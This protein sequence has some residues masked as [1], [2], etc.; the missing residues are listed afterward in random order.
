MEIGRPPEAL[1]LTH[2]VPTGSIP[3]GAPLVVGDGDRA[4]FVQSG[5]V[6]GVLEAGRYVAD[7]A[8]VAFLG[9]AVRPGVRALDCET[10]FV[11]QHG[12]VD[13]DGDVGD[14]AIQAVL[15]VEVAD[16][17]AAALQLLIGRT[18]DEQLD[19]QLF[20]A[21]PAVLDR[22]R[23][24]GW[25]EDLDQAAEALALAAESDGLGFAQYGARFAGF[26]ELHLTETSDAGPGGFAP[27]AAV[28]AQSRDGRW[29]PATIARIDS[30]RFEI[31]WDDGRRDW[32][33]PY[34][35]RPL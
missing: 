28:L 19:H 11:R 27:G 20:R 15:D 30:G 16:A 17:S 8:Q 21:L 2:H 23:A 3:V 18:L 12:T 13:V 26:V 7:P 10:W 9:W 35:L 34:Q 31:L 1:G 4:V 33:T 25:P 22:V 14:L 5:R 29:A 24:R 6:L 32:V